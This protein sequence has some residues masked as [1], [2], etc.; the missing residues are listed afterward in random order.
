MD[1]ATAL[2]TELSLLLLTGDLGHSRE[3]NQIID[4]VESGRAGGHLKV[5][6]SSFFRRERNEL[7]P[8]R[9]PAFSILD[10]TVSRN[11]RVIGKASTVSE[12][13]IN[14]AFAFIGRRTPRK[15]SK[16]SI[17]INE[18]AS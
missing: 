12:S 14:T 7:H 8:S 9:L 2:F 15:E 5:E 6:A 10:F 17:T 3:H 13:M 11:S 18:V 1:G 4:D 16:L